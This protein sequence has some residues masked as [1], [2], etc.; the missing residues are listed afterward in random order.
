MAAAGECGMA[1]DECLQALDLLLITQPRDRD[2]LGI[3]VVLEAVGAIKHVRASP[4]HAGAKVASGRSEDDDGPTRHVLA[5]VVADALD[6]GVA[7][8]VADTEAL[9]RG[10]GGIQ[11]PAGRAIHHG[12]AHDDVLVRGEDHLPR[13]C[14]DNLPASHTFANVVVSF[15]LEDEP[16]PVDEK[17]A[18]ALAGGPFKAQRNRVVW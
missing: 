13:R 4:T 16:H 2:E 11:R 7:P 9:T 12:V 1:L 15:A 6:D 8:T 14:D 3:V 5:A 10:A 17:R 18:K